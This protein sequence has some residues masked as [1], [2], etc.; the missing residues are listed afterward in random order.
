MDKVMVLYLCLKSLM[1]LRDTL[2]KE[3]VNEKDHLLSILN[4]GMRILSISF[5]C[6]KITAPKRIE[7]ETYL[8][9]FGYPIYS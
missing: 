8:L 6:E 2:T 7:Q 3:E 5:N 1:T 4:H 9:L